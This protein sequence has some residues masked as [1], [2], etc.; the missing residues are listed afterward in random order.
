MSWRGREGRTEGIRGKGEGTRK[1]A[2]EGRKKGRKRRRARTQH[3][4]APLPSCP[5]REEGRRE[6]RRERGGREEEPFV[7]AVA[8]GAAL[9][10]PSLY[11]RP[12]LCVALPGSV[13][14]PNTS[15]TQGVVVSL[16][17]WILQTS[18]CHAL[19]V[20]T[21]L[22]HS[23]DS[24]EVLVPLDA[25]GVCGGGE[26]HTEPAVITQ[27]FLG[28][29]T[30]TRLLEGFTGRGKVLHLWL[31]SQTLE[32]ERSFH[33]RTLPQHV[34]SPEARRAPQGIHSAGQWS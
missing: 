12:R 9:G 31:L 26:L 29:V 8:S 28:Q 18:G 2:K 15:D 6:R 33:P 30:S 22:T 27:A 13:F 11:H 20:R 4:P 19:L 5:Q 1:R 23:R 25:S 34:H 21:E 3:S 10:P 24:D 17:L 32:G 14:A 16:S 7:C